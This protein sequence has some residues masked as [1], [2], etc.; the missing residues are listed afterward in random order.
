MIGRFKIFALGLIIGSAWLISGWAAPTEEDLEAIAGRIAATQRSPEPAEIQSIDEAIA[1][2]R[3]GV[4]ARLS[5]E[6]IARE[7]GA[8][9][10]Q[11]EAYIKSLAYLRRAAIYEKLGR[12]PHVIDEQFVASAKLGNLQAINHLVRKYVDSAKGAGP[13]KAVA[14]KGVDIDDII[15]VGLDLADARSMQAAVDGFGTRERSRRELAFYQLLLALEKRD[16]SFVADVTELAS[17]YD[18][19]AVLNEYAYVGGP[20]TAA[21]SGTYSRDLLATLLAEDNFRGTWARGLGFWMADTRPDQEP[22][23]REII[24]MNVWLTDMSGL[25]TAFHYLTQESDV[26]HSIALTSPQIAQQLSAGNT[27]HVRCGGLAHTAVVFKVDRQQD[28]ILLM[29]PLYQFW[30]PS[31]NSCITNFK[32]THYRYGYYLT[33]LSLSE[34]AGIVIAVQAFGTYQPPDQVFHVDD[35]PHDKVSAA[36]GRMARTCTASG[37]AE[38]GFLGHHL[39]PLAKR[40]LFSFFNLHEL[41]R[42]VRDGQTFV[43][44]M[45][46]AVEFR[47][48]VI[49]VARTDEADCA[50][51]FSLFLRRSFLSGTN[52]MFAADIT[53]SFLKQV[54]DSNQ[55]ASLTDKSVAERISGVFSGSEEM[56]TVELS[57]A[58]LRIKNF[59]SETS[60]KWLRIDS[61]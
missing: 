18:L 30:Q 54:F 4:A 47:G 41:M 38:D 36:A 19:P 14:L 59:A 40:D 15:D 56:E 17:H 24:A 25:A 22:N 53:R 12:D 21:A 49:L 39:G 6:V 28:Q 60:A 33:Q 29:D 13:A 42:R 32:L 10:P 37:D 3:L 61:L 26:P 51:S 11:R 5:A 7:S 58:T 1:G 35:M 9:S 45:P 44:F 57:G 55:K 31:H 23:L 43:V 2:K 50:Q 20:V 48:D 46:A 27:I 34:V 8:S 52:D 16:S